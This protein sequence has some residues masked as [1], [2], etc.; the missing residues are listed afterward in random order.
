MIGVATSDGESCSAED[1]ALAEF[2]GKPWGDADSDEG[3]PWSALE[4][5]IER[6]K[7]RFVARYQEAFRA[8]F[9]AGQEASRAEV[10]LQPAPTGIV[11]R[12]LR[13]YIQE[14]HD[15]IDSVTDHLNGV[16]QRVEKLEAHPER[17]GSSEKHF[18]RR[19]ESLEKHI[20]TNASLST[21]VN[22][23]DNHASNAKR[24]DAIEDKLRLLARELG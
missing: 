5:S 14:I 19:L 21:F 3:N 20:E 17:L 23:D 18:D 13:G 2:D 4:E 16:I 15:R 6:T 22:I 12:E 1:M 24:L 10:E 11:E 7:A 8:G 9:R